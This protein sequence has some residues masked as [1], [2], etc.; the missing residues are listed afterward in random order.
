MET[1]SCILAWRTPQTKELGATV[2]KVARSQTRRSRS[3][4]QQSAYRPI[5][6]F[7]AVIPPQ[8]AGLWHLSPQLDAEPPAG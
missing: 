1:H 8:V 3:T 2:H 7:T 6:V 4:T 5:H